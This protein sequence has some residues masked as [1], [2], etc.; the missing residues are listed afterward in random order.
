MAMASNLDQLTSEQ[1]FELASELDKKGRFWLVRQLLPTLTSEQLTDLLTEVDETLSQVVLDEEG[2]LDARAKFNIKEVNNNFYAYIEHWG[3]AMYCNLYIGPLRIMPGIK[4]KLTH[5][6]T[7]EV[8][9]LA[10][11]GIYREGE[12]VYLRIQH[13]TPVNEEKSYL[14]YDRS[15]RFPRRPQEEGIDPLFGRKEWKIEV[16]GKLEETLEPDKEP[17]AL[18]PAPILET[19]QPR[20]KILHTGKLNSIPSSA[21]K[22]EPARAKKTHALI[23]TKRKFATQ[24]EDYLEQWELLSQA[25]PS[26]PQWKLTPYAD[27]LVLLNQAQEVVVEFNNTSQTLKTTS[28]EALL[29]WLQEIMFSVASSK[30]VNQQMQSAANQWLTLLASAPLE[31]SNQLLAYLFNL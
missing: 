30:L 23:R 16:I 6:K 24:I 4:Y 15:H 2:A 25:I 3:R 31:D 13:L 19:P 9:T 10:G 8:K 1:I 18:E 20:K 27:G 5:K 11:L 17:A 22:T 28:A 26:N 12:Q 21:P 7:K 14:F 29:S